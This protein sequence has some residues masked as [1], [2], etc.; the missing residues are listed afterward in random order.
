MNK[1]MDKKHYRSTANFF[2]VITI[3]LVILALQVNS[4]KAQVSFITNGQSIQATNSW[5]IKLVDINGD[6]NLDTE[7][8]YAS[9]PCPVEIWV[10]KAFESNY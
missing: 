1:K 6:G 5:D 7:N 2:K 10:N 9:V 4:V 8:S 3:G